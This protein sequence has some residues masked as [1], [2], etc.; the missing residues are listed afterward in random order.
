LLIVSL[1]YYIYAEA[2]GMKKGDITEVESKIFPSTSARCIQFSYNMYGADVGSLSVSVIDVKTGA[3]TTIFTKSGNQGQQ[4]Y[5][6]QAAITSQNSYKVL[7]LLRSFSKS[8]SIKRL[9]LQSFKVL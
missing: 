7:K 5:K 2:S 6:V 8:F 9:D 3:E 1:G 4:W